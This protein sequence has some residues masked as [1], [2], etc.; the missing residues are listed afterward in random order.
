MSSPILLG[1]SWA[2]DDAT[3][4]ATSEASADL[5][6]ENVQDSDIRKPWRSSTLNTQ[7]LVF[8]YGA[9]RQC[10]YIYLGG[11]NLTTAA[12]ISVTIATDSAFASPVYDASFSPNSHGL[13]PIFGD[14]QLNQ[15]GGDKLK[16]SA[17]DFL[18]DGSGNFLVS[19]T[20]SLPA[21]GR[22]CR[23]SINDPANTDGYVEV[24]RIKIGAVVTDAVGHDWGASV[25]TVDK[26]QV[27]RTKGGSMYILP[28]SV[29]RAVTVGWSWMTD[30]EMA[31]L[32]ALK[33][34]Y[35]AREDVVLS[36][37]PDD[38]GKRGA[39]YTICGR[40]VAW[41]PATRQQTRTHSNG[42]RVEGAT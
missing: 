41:A 27:A 36:V 9:S 33:Y 14:H 10:D 22:Y 8:D 39:M 1:H 30:T 2:D 37:Y 20:W 32:E 4:T 24:G 26:S 5:G 28:G 25:E 3:P 6:V 34:D 19:G 11:M 40:L 23:V 16:D 38:T 13:D 29:F 35:G 21:T 15:T 17:G 42:I 18:I 12:E 31:A 7:H